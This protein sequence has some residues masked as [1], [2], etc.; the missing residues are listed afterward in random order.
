VLRAIAETGV[1]GRT[2]TAVL[3]RPVF[4]ALAAARSGADLV[5][6]GARGKTLLRQA[7]PRPPARRPLARGA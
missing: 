5:Y 2:Q 7:V 3:E 1:H 4:E 6:V